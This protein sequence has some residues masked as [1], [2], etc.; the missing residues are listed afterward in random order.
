MNKYKLYNIIDKLWN[1]Y[2]Q[3]IKFC[4]IGVI[5]VGIFYTIY[6]I[7]LTLDVNYLLANTIACL[8]AILNGYI[9]SSKFVFEKNKSINNMMKFF[10]VYISSLF[11][12][13]GIIYICVDYYNINKLVAPIFAIGIVTIYNYT[14]NKIWTFRE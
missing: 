12:N 6:Y 14:L 5:N 4:I 8:I 13:L 1:R 10:I 2:L 9:W 11:I 7:L 3:F